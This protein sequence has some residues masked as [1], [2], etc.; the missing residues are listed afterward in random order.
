MTFISAALLDVVSGLELLAGPFPAAPFL[1]PGL[2]RRDRG[3]DSGA[4][5]EKQYPCSEMDI[6]LA[7]YILKQSE[8]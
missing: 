5:L 8:A 2:L 1:R 6:L 7:R 4:E 3:A